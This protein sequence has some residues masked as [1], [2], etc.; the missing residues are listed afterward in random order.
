MKD[1]V[2]RVVVFAVILIAG[3]ILVLFDLPAIIL[4]LVIIVLAGLVLLISGSV[5]LP[6]LRLPKITRSPGKG[7]KT[8]DKEQ[9]PP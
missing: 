4:V 5:K 9:K 6:K 8:Q 7:G 1:S 2:R 3:L